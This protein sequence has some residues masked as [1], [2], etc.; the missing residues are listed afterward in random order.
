MSTRARSVPTGVTTDEPTWFEGRDLRLAA[1]VWGH[2]TDPPVVLLPGGGQTRHAWN[3]TARRL[4][5]KGWRTVALDARGH[6][7]SDW[8][9]DADYTV[10]A[11]VDDLRRVVT[12]LDRPPVVIGASRGGLTALV[13]VAEDPPT[14]ARALVL[15]DVAPR[16]EPAGIERIRAFMT[17]RPDGFESLEEVADTIAAYH[18]E[19]PRPRDLDGLRKV[20]RQR[21]DGRWVWHWDPAYIWRKPPA[22]PTAAHP[23]D[24]SVLTD[25]ARRVTIPTLLVRGHQS[26]VLSQEGAAELRRLIPHARFADVAGAGHMLAGDRNTVFADAI[27]QFMTSLAKEPARTT[28]PRRP[29]EAR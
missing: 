20:V 26:D 1:T 19:R 11:Q 27:L 9:I 10:E 24:A 15:V 5:A 28:H 4:T 7:D 3:A 25:A 18:P 12:S 6:G 8:A 22:D 2:S 21:P 23:T 13:A 14:F 16:L 17:S 29:S